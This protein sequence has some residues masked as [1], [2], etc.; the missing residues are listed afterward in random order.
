MLAESLLLLAF[1]L[2]GAAAQSRAADGRLRDRVWLAFF[3]TISP[4]LVFVTFLTVEVDGELALALAAVVAATW[5]IGVVAYAYAALVSD[6]RDERGALALG[7]AFGNTGFVGY[8]LAQLAFGTNGLSLAVLYDRLAWLVPA[9]AVSTAAARLHALRDAGDARRESRLR[10]LL[11]NPPLHAL[12]V[13]L[14]L[15]AA[16]VHVPFTDEARSLAGALVGPVGFFL[17]GL[18]LPLERPAHA[19]V[20]LRR[21]AGALAIRLAGGPLA[22]FAAAYLLGADVPAVFYL[23]AGMPSAFH[24]LV[25]ARVYELR[26]ALMRLLVVGSTVPAVVAVVLV[27]GAR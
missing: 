22:L 15:R 3:W 14:A 21:A 2:L 23:L 7:A 16:G 12:V 24:L 20:E 27:A 5:T 1:L 26:P 18:S 10:A 8:P 9:T 17:L 13:A 6:A 19:A 11:A 4:V 25:L